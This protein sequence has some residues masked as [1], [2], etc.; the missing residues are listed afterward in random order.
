MVWGYSLVLLLLEG[1]V[2]LEMD[3]VFASSHAKIQL[4]FVLAVLIG[5]HS[6]SYTHLDVYKRQIK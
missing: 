4:L 1:A 6:V 3:A 2:L 5:S